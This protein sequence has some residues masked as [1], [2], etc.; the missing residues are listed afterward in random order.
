MTDNGRG[1]P[2]D[3]RFAVWIGATAVLFLAAGAV[4]FGLLSSAQE[5]AGGH[6]LWASIRRAAGL[7]SG[8]IRAVVPAAGQPASTVAWTVATRRT[9]T[10]G[11]A[12]R[13]AAL[14]T[15]CNNCHG[16]NGVSSD[17]A[18]PN[19]V[20]QSVA[21]IYKQLE[22][23]KSGKRNPAVMGVFVAPLSQGDMLDLAAYFASQSNPFARE[24]ATLGSG[25]PAARNLIE[26][27]SPM[28]NIASCAACHGPQGLTPGAPELRG[29][30]R[31]YLEQ[32]MQ[33]FK[34]GNRHNDISEQMRSVAR[35][36]TDEEIAMLAAYYSS[37]TDMT[38]RVGLWKGSPGAGSRQR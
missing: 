10:R 33:A 3:H 9:L 16:A 35:Q 37:F 22:D 32:E 24:P 1:G 19:L 31:A 5:G 34:T 7:P 11:D 21:A 14:A 29:Q 20:G 2:P 38:G 8:G 17:A 23:F 25:S 6:D 28:R 15:T 27:G 4:G 30:Q 26:V 13:G 18:I 12:V 36:L